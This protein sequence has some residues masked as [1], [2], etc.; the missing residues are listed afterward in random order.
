[1]QE[2]VKKKSGKL[3]IESVGT[4]ETAMGIYIYTVYIVYICKH[5][6]EEMPVQR[7]NW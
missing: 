1:M 5:F 4:S 7:F 3:P 6:L 2:C